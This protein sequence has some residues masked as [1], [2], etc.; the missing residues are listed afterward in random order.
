MGE[1]AAAAPVTQMRV[2]TLAGQ[3]P[4]WAR[5]IVAYLDRWHGGGAPHQDRFYR[6][7][8]CTRLVSWRRI[9]AGGCR[10]GGARLRATALGFGDKVRILLMPWSI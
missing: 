7:A 6:C 1:R 10:C 8:G 4:W 5:P 2:I 3:H 9:R